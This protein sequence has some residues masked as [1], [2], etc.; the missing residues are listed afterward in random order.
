MRKVLFLATTIGLLLA[1]SQRKE[2]AAAP[3]PPALVLHQNGEALP[4][5]SPALAAPTADTLLAV[6]KMPVK[7]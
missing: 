7:L 1:Y 4:K 6:R 2:R 5:A 3:R